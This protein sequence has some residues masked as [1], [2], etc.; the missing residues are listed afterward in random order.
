MNIVHILWF[1][2]QNGI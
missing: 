2:M 1:E